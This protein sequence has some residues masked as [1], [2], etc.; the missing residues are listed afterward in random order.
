MKDF[1][2]CIKTQMNKKIAFLFFSDEVER[3][4]EWQKEFVYAYG[5]RLYDECEGNCKP[6]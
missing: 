3:E 5:F 2:F 4:S 1:L 6:P